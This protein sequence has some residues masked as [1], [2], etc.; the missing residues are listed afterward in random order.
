VRRLS[1]SWVKL[2]DRGFMGSV[3]WLMD[4]GRDPKTILYDRLALIVPMS[5]TP[6]PYLSRG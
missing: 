4:I 3:S 5:Y 6:L 1:H 2:L